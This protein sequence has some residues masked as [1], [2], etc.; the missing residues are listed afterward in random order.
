MDEELDEFL[1]EEKE[2]DLRPGG[3][4]RLQ[5]IVTNPAGGSSELATVPL[6]ARLWRV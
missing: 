2:V 5:H 3:P 4:V 1:R 6:T